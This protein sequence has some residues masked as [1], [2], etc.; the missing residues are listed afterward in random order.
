MTAIDAPAGEVWTVDGRLC[1]LLGFHENDFYGFN[2]NWRYFF[3][4]EQGQLY[5]FSQKSSFCAELT[6]FT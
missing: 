3:D 5:F 4:I 1:I 6:K 2:H